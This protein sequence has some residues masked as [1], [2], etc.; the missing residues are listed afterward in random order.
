MALREETLDKNTVLNAIDETV[1][2]L[3]RDETAVS[4]G[5]CDE[6]G[7]GTAEWE[8]CR[9]QLIEDLQSAQEW[10]EREDA[11]ERE[12]GRCTARRFA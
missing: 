9:D 10:V 4:S 8:A 1:H 6:L 7:I 11:L 12:R 5:A 3:E 2:T